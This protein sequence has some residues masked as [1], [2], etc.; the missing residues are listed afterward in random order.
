MPF[1]GFKNFAACV[2]AQKKKG[3]SDESAKKICGAL[4]KKAEGKHLTDDEL[5]AL[6]LESA[7]AQWI[8]EV[9]KKDA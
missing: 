9:L 5:M 1:A 4:Q 2:A 8:S 7:E 6:C 3:K